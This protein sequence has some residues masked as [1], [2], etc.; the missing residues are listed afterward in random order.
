M[1]SVVAPPLPPEISAFTMYV[2]PICPR[3]YDHE[4]AHSWLTRIG[5]VYALNAERLVGILGLVPFEA[6]SRRNIALPVEAA[7]DGPNLTQLAVATQLPTAH[8]TECG[9]TQSNGR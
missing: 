4:A 9:L 3:P 2:L 1:R 5:R 6:G 7:L 8:L